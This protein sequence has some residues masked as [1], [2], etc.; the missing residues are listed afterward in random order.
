MASEILLHPAS[1]ERLP[2]LFVAHGSPTNALET[3]DFTR[4]LRTW[5]LRL[6]RP[7]AIV[8]LSAHWLTRGLKVGSCAN[9]E[10]IH[11]F[12]GF[13][14]QL[15]RVYYPA[16]GAPALAEHIAEQ[17]SPGQSDGLLDPLR[18]LDHGAWSVLLHLFPL[19][20]IP[21]IPLS[22][23][24]RATP[25]QHFDLGRRLHWLRDEGVLFVASGNIVHNLREVAWDAPAAD[26]AMEFDKRVATAVAE[27]RTEEL[28]AL[29]TAA[30][31]RGSPADSITRSLFR[32][33]HPSADHWWPLLTFLGMAAPCE[34]PACTYDQ[35][36]HG[37]ISQRCWQLG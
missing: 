22:V 8:V 29:G 27:Q 7:Q 15:Q 20:E 16:R 6:P 33:A 21:V 23:D 26:W 24:L 3:N 37:C 10:T 18:G 19:A 17:L 12:Y 5:G 25:Q 11:D 13:D 4:T 36:E 28:L 34:V 31:E 14:E 30:V 9:P 1:S 35:I 2:A 32:R